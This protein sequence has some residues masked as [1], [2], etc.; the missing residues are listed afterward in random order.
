MVPQP[1][2]QD[3]FHQYFFERHRSALIASVLIEP[4]TN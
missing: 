3:A 1:G 4:F 2:T